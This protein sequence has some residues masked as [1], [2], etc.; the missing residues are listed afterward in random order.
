[1]QSEGYHSVRGAENWPRA[2]AFMIKR[3]SLLGKLDGEFANALQTY[4][5][6]GDDALRLVQHVTSG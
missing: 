4:V 2:P 6:I 3:I 1:L 5:R